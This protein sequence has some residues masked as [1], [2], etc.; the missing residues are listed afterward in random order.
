MGRPS[1]LTVGHLIRIVGPDLKAFQ[2]GHREFSA[3]RK[4]SVAQVMAQGRKSHNLPVEPLFFGGEGA[5]PKNLIKS[6]PR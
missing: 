2:A 4:G 5:V 6:A 1:F 3:V